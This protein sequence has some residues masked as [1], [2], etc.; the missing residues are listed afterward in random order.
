MPWPP[1]PHQ[2][3]GVQLLSAAPPPHPEPSTARPPAPSQRHM[4]TLRPGPRTPISFWVSCASLEDRLPSWYSARTHWIAGVEIPEHPS[5]AAGPVA[6]VGAGVAGEPGAALPC[7]AVGRAP[8]QR[9]G[10]VGHKQRHAYPRVGGRVHSKPRSNGSVGLPMGGGQVRAAAAQAP[11]CLPLSKPRRCFY[12]F[13]HSRLHIPCSPQPLASWPPAWLAGTSPSAP[14][15]LLHDSHCQ[16]RIASQ[17]SQ[18][19]RILLA[20][21]VSRPR[22][23]GA[24]RACRLLELPQ[25]TTK[26]SHCSR[27]TNPRPAYAL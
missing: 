17:G 24:A 4:P 26:N 1:H 12:T 20:Q 6:G 18:A 14:K 13:S 9:G 5:V 3:L 23:V 21:R 11:P 25:C 2:H 8:A 16:P 19:R 15:A 22:P 7:T 27:H 10:W